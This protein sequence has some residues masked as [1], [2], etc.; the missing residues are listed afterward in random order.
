MIHDRI[1]TRSTGQDAASR[2]RAP[3]GADRVRGAL[4]PPSPA[5]GAQPSSTTE[6]PTTTCIAV[7]ASPATPRSTRRVD[8][9]IHPGRVTRMT[10]SAP[11]E[12]EQSNRHGLRSCPTVTAQQYRRP[13]PWMTSSAPTALQGR[14]PGSFTANHGQSEPLLRGLIRLY[15]T[16][17]KL[18]INHMAHQ[19]YRKPEIFF[20]FII[21]PTIK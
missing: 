19:F 6:V 10:S 8:T 14:H 4:Q 20:Q 11:T 16:V 17:P 1:H 21:I 18:L 2:F 13:R 3:H 15:R 7:P 5:P 12:I 9:R